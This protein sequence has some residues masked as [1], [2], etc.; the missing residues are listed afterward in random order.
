M[1]VC[2]PCVCLVPMEA[3]EGNGY[4][5]NGVIDGCE[6]PDGPAPFFNGSDD[7]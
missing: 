5:G 1:Y 6:P 2:V 7:P 4:P 3:R